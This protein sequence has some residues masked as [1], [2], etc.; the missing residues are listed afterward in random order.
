[1]VSLSSVA[2]RDVS[3]V[4]GLLCDK[5]A[6]PRDTMNGSL[7]SSYTFYP[8][9]LLIINS[10]FVCPMICALQPYSMAEN[11]ICKASCGYLVHFY[12]IL[13]VYLHF[14]IL[15]YC[16]TEQTFW[17]TDSRQA[18]KNSSALCRTPNFASPDSTG[19]IPHPHIL[20]NIRFNI[21]FIFVP[22]SSNLSLPFKFWGWNSF[23]FFT[24]VLICCHCQ[25]L[26]FSDEAIWIISP[27]RCWNG[28]YQGSC[29]CSI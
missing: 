16:F 29:V 10:C 3:A 18:G 12:I 8:C 11:D 5:A 21:I 9:I 26:K 14:C 2:V 22:V 25:K 1:M 13:N 6:V 23:C 4:A 27:C 20:F 15:L 24:R 17:D 7:L 19:S 28:S